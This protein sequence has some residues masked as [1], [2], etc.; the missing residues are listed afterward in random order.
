MAVGAARAA[1]RPPPLALVSSVIDD[2][3]APSA[4]ESP[5]SQSSFFPAARSVDNNF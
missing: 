1:R 2:A 3:V 5:E 4:F